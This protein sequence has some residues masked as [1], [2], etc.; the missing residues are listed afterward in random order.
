MAK[1]VDPGL[2]GYHQMAVTS[3]SNDPSGNMKDHSTAL[4]PEVTF[5]F[6]N[7]TFFVSARYLFE[8]F[9]SG[10]PQ[11]TTINISPRGFNRKAHKERQKRNK[12]Y[13]QW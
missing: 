8:A 12:G 11:G 1:T 10:R 2:S 13:I 9:A 5:A 7:K 3:A 4:G 6:P